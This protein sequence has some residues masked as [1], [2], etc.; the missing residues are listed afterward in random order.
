MKPHI[1]ALCLT[2]GRVD[3]LNESIQMFL[4]QTYDGPKRML[5]YNTFTKQK[6]IG[7]F[8]NVEIINAHERPANL[9]ACR[10]KAIAFCNEGLIC[11][12]DD[13]DVFLPNHLENF[14]NHYE[15][16]LSWLWHSHQFY[17]CGYRVEKL[18]SGTPN[19][20][21][22]TKAAWKEVGG[23]PDLNVGED[24]S[25]MGKL[26]T[27][28]GKK[29]QLAPNR[30]SFLYCW[31]Q[32]VYHTSG[33]SDDQKGMP[34]A[35]DRIAEHTHR[36]ARIGHIPTGDIKLAPE[37]RHDY[38]E[39][40]SHFLAQLNRAHQQSVTP[41]QPP[42]SSVPYQP[43]Q[44]LTSI[45]SI[46][47]VY[48]YVPGDAGHSDLASRFVSSYVAHPPGVTH[49]TII[50]C[51]GNPPD[52]TAKKLFS[53]L[54]NTTFYKH[55]DSGWDIGAFLAV[56]KTCKTDIILCIGGQGHV[57]RAGWMIRMVEAW[58]KHGEGFY[59][60]L[61]SYEVS[62]HLNTSGFWSSPRILQQYPITVTT[63]QQRYNFEH[64]PDACWRMALNMGLPVLLVTWCG[65]YDWFNWRLPSNLY[66]RGDQSNCLTYF[67]HTVLFDQA[68]PGMKV[69]MSGYADTITDIVF[70]KAKS[71]TDLRLQ[72][73]GDPSR[74][75]PN[76]IAHKQLSAP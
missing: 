16:G 51:N 19:T 29:I 52:D 68:D 57:K 71:R 46:T 36:E 9:G 66:R 4:N 69:A 7:D 56:A 5:V 64:G 45:P 30:V 43:A 49:K 1:T 39:L 47:L 26:M 73:S 44:P 13:D 20:L 38:E 22:F 33:L 53:C 31:G 55:D 37:L 34:T 17:M 21:A 35:H 48:I 75:N 50:V 14:A 63:F 3:F 2:Y 40:V 74:F 70:I 28:P 60:S 54:P 8:P 24:R 61:S 11:I 6:L 32:G 18:C 59:G 76:S 72:M 25:L 42:G 67:K 65:E 23:Y 27:L 12:W 41:P 10:N 58:Q 15:E 62:P